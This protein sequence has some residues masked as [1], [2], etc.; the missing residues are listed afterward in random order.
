MWMNVK[1]TCVTIVN[2][3]STRK[4]AIHVLVDEAI[5]LCLMACLVQMWMNVQKIMVDVNIFV[6]MI[7]EGKYTEQL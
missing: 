2:F 1:R 6:S 3:V 5:S 4:A 7:E